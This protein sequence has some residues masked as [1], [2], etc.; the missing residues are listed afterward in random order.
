M[1]L[2]LL[3]TMTVLPLS[4]PEPMELS[5]TRLQLYLVTAAFDFVRA[6]SDKPRNVARIEMAGQTVAREELIA[7]VG[8]VCPECALIG[9][10]RFWSFQTSHTS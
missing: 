3:I 7:H 9:F 2:L 1:L 6:N 4:V 8:R 10:Y 5:L